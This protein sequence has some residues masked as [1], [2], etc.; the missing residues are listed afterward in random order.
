MEMEVPINDAT[1]RFQL[2]EYDASLF[3]FYYVATRLR[4]GK[5]EFDS[6]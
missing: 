4:V 5:P 6:R 1:R 3:R 2:T